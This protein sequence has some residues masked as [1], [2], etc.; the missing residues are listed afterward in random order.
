MDPD[1]QGYLLVTEVCF[2]GQ[3]THTL[4]FY[5]RHRPLIPSVFVL[6]VMAFGLK[7][8]VCVDL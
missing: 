8:S 3:G 7:D 5:T 6:A 1:T 4:G 2:S